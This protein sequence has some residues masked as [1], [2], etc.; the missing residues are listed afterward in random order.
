[1]SG[2]QSKMGSVK[3]WSQK[4][5]VSLATGH[6]SP[7]VQDRVALEWRGVS[8]E[9][10]AVRGPAE[11]G[12]KWDG[13]R[14]YIA[15]HDLRLQDGETTLEGE[16]VRQLDLR[17]K[18]TFVP[19]GATVTGWSRLARPENSF[20]AVYYDPAIIP[21][22]LEASISGS[23]R[24]MLYFK[25]AEL[26][27]VLKRLQALLRN[28]DAADAVYAE[29]LG[30]LAALEIDRL[31][32]NG[33]GKIANVGTLSV[34]QEQMVRDYIEDNIGRPIALTELASLVKLSRFHFLRAFRKTT[35]VPPHKYVL[36]RRIERAKQLLASTEDPIHAVAETLGFG[37]QAAFARTFG[38]IAGCSPSQFRRAQR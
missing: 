13:P 9:H 22:E 19:K 5:W 6:T 4:Q 11:F 17:E 20:T 8:A 28:P 37:N 36:Q 38:Q 16:T 33:H 24:P 34:R 31:Q 32:R 15:I 1:M 10:V 25:N 27:F 12:Y 7:M 30:L 26:G 23:D 14:N 18:L 2:K 29:T 21:A 35:G 3:R